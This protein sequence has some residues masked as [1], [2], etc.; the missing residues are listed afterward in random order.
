[1]LNI[2][3]AAARPSMHLH[4]SRHRRGSFV[5]STAVGTHV[6]N[7]FAARQARAVHDGGGVRRMHAVV[8]PDANKE[9]S[10]M[11]W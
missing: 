1:V 10:L 9:H 11:R 3:T 4:A 8:M 5:G 6:Y 7:S 2:I